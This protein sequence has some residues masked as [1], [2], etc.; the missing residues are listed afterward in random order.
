LQLSRAAA[1]SDGLTVEASKMWA[2]DALAPEP[3]WLRR[4]P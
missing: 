4:Q 3:H 2:L 1:D